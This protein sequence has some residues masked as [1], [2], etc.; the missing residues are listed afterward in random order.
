MKEKS[1][2]Q[3]IFYFLLHVIRILN[4]NAKANVAYKNIEKKKKTNEMEKI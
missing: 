4:S 1:E 2:K 3:N